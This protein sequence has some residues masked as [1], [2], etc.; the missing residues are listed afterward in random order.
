MCILRLQYVL[1]YF[2]VFYIL[3]LS[4]LNFSFSMYSK[5]LTYSTYLTFKK[6][7]EIN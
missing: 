1:E 3:E 6:D 2:E 5:N 4:C 7:F